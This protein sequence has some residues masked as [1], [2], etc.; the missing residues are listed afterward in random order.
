MAAPPVAGSSS[1]A[2]NAQTLAEIVK[3]DFLLVGAFLIFL[4]LIS[5]D[6]Y[7]RA[8]GLRFQF[9]TYPWNLIIFRGLLTVV[10]FPWL[11]LFLLV[12]ITA[13]QFDRSLSRNPT[14]NHTWRIGAGYLCIAIVVACLPQFGTYLGAREA[15]T[16]MEWGTTTLPRITKVVSSDGQQEDCPHC[17]LLLMDSSEVVY[18]GALDKGENDALPQTHIRARASVTSIDTSR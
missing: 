7:Y 10:R 16:D 3:A 5:T 17:L 9:L 14:L 15:A 18:F 2:S 1:S 6:A 4:G 11:W 13:F 8:F 12:M